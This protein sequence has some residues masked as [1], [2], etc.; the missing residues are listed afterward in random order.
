MSQREELPWFLNAYIEAAGVYTVPPVFH[1]WA[2]LSVLAAFTSKRVSYEHIPG[3]PLYPNLYV[4]LIAKSAAGKGL[5]ISHAVRLMG[6]ILGHEVLEMPHVFEGR[7]TPQALVGRLGKI[8]KKAADKQAEFFF[9]SPELGQSLDLPT[10]MVGRFIKMMT[11]LYDSTGRPWRD[12]TRMYGELKAP[13]SWINWLAGTTS[14]WLRNSVGEEDFKGG[15]TGRLL[16]IYVEDRMD[17]RYR[18]KLPANADALVAHLRNHL[19][20]L[21]LTHGRFT[22]DGE[23]RDAD[24]ARSEQRYNH[25]PRDERLW[26]FYERGSTLAKKLAML[27]ALGRSTDLRLTLKDIELGYRTVANVERDL[28]R[29]LD[30]VSETKETRGLDLMRDMIEK[31]GRIP[32]RML[33]SYVTKNLGITRSTILE[34]EATLLMQQVIRVDRRTDEYVWIKRRFTLVRGGKVQSGEDEGE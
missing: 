19:L 11:G 1:Y 5:A 17:F 28:P 24:E 23:A 4:F 26:P 13:P 31:A 21:R 20:A 34:Y 8:G 2:G 30:L 29:V 10:N 12:D 15:F 14:T 33:A 27:F 32:R 25:L 6:A 16:P 18:P 7:T 3:N 9:V 22:M